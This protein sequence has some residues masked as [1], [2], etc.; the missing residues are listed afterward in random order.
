MFAKNESSARETE[1]PLKNHL[2]QKE[3]RK[4]P[5]TAVDRNKATV[6]LTPREI[7]FVLM[8]RWRE[9]KDG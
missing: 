8:T 5:Q 1:I 4:Y 6:P 7:D 3:E 9:E 2:L